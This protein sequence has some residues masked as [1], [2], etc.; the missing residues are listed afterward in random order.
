ML[1][2]EPP[3]IGPLQSRGEAEYNITMNRPRQF[4]LMGE[5]ASIRRD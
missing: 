2:V 5:V 1:L 3:Q 4:Q